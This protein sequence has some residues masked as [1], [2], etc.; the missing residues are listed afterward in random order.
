MYK[1]YYSPFEEQPVVRESVARA[2]AEPEVI[3]PKKAALPTEE[4]QHIRD[5]FEPHDSRGVPPLGVSGDKKGTIFGGMNTEDI[6]LLGILALLLMEDKEGRDIP[7]V[8]AIGF[9]LLAEYI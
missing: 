5:G 1:K 9:L 6:I 4:P 7:L 2:A 3:T 8:L